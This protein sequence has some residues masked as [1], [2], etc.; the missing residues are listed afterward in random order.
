MQ[1]TWPRVI[2]LINGKSCCC[3]HYYQIIS[4]DIHVWSF[5]NN[6]VS[7]PSWDGIIAAAAKSLQ[8]CPTLCN[9]MDC[10]PPGPSIHG[11]FQ[12]KA[13]E[14]VPSPSPM[15]ESE[16]RRWSCSVMSD[17]QRLHGLQPTRPLCP[18]DFPGKSTG[19]GAIAFSEMGSQRCVKDWIADTC[20][21]RPGVVYKGMHA[22][23]QSTTNTSISLKSFYIFFLLKKNILSFYFLFF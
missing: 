2:C 20:V 23:C 16:K 11:I 13:L 21:S 6:N 22:V 17:P 18:W 8:S 12:A 10:S 3:S 7:M 1:S 14:W 15:H 19:V 9:P 4:L 5:R